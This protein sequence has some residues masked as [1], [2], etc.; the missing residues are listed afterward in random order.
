MDKAKLIDG[1]NSVV[2]TDT[3]G[4]KWEDD[5]KAYLTESLEG[6]SIVPDE[7]TGW[8]IHEGLANLN[9]GQSPTGSMHDAYKAMIASKGEGNNE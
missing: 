7:P 2:D 6:Y 1:I 4:L 8:M 9:P 5:I 3:N